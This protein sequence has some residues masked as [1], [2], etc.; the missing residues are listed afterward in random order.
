MIFFNIFLFNIY[1]ILTV[2][3]FSVMYLDKKDLKK[4]YDNNIVLSKRQINNK[5]F[6]NL[7]IKNELVR[8]DKRQFIL[9]QHNLYKNKIPIVLGNHI[10]RELVIKA[11]MAIQVETCLQFRLV[12]SLR[13]ATSGINFYN[14]KG[15]NDQF[16]DTIFFKWQN[17]SLNERCHS[18]GS[19]YQQIFR[20]LGM[21]FEHQR[22]CRDHYIILI[23]HNW[24]L[25]KDTYFQL[26]RHNKMD[27]FSYPYDYGSVMQNN[28]KFFSNGNGKTMLPTSELYTKTIGQ[29]EYPSFLDFKRLN[30]FYCSTK[31]RKKVECKNGGYLNPNNCIKCKCIYGFYGS[32]C[33]KFQRP[34]R[35]CVRTQFEAKFYA[36]TLTNSGI[37]ECAYQIIAPTGR[38]IA[39]RVLA[40]KIYPELVT[41]CSPFNTL[42][43]KYWRDK[44]A[45]GVRLCGVT[46]SIN[47]VTRDNF[48][49]L[50]FRSLKANNMFYLQYKVL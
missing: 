6:H 10:Y 15:C 49:L 30:N 31:C 48:A 47:I 16:M 9:K 21:I 32:F 19:I 44:T 11:L 39:I 28:W 3:S 27:D 37:K 13:E 36:E 46:S 2:S 33:E 24:M 34:S 7:E 50:Y 41:T 40:V 8:R 38:H 17:I 12:S 23:K 35:I 14:G 5:E 26:I 45:T 25:F 29:N 43:I 22:K 20:T 4:S 42:E 1:I 18:P